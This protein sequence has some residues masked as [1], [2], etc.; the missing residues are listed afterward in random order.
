MAI[1]SLSEKLLTS[2]VQFPFS[3]RNPGIVSPARG[4]R[5]VVYNSVII[6]QKSAELLFSLQPG[7]RP[8]ADLERGIARAVHVQK[9]FGSLATN[10]ASAVPY[11]RDL[12]EERHKYIDSMLRSA[13]KHLSAQRQH[14]AEQGAQVEGARLEA[15]RRAGACRGSRV[16]LFLQSS[17]GIY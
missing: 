16:A 14:E 2:V 17:C 11:D 3:L 15:R 4:H 9:M 12:T 13:E 5:A 7:K 8:L 1:I 6:Q 10:P